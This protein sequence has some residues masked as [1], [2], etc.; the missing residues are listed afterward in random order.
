MSDKI[1]KDMTFFEVMRTYPESVK[2]LQKYNLGCIGCMGAQNESL[3]QGAN[4]H[5]IDAE[6]LVKDLNAA[7]A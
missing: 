5:G 3:E 1:T 2:V 6:T 7:V 4:A